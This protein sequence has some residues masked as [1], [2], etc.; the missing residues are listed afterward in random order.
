MERRWCGPDFPEWEADE[1]G[2]VYRNGVEVRQNLVESRREGWYF[3][4]SLGRGRMVFVHRLVAFAFHGDPPEWAPMV[5]H[6]NDVGTDNRPSNLYW[7]NHLTN[8]WDREENAL[9]R[10]G[11]DVELDWAPVS[12]AIIALRELAESSPENL[13]ELELIAAGMRARAAEFRAENDRAERGVGRDTVY[14]VL[15]AA[16]DRVVGGSGDDG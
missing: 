12:A 7:G 13:R 4:V 16:E 10:L 8:A 2:R 6:R 5:C 3:Q 15:R 11:V 14:R 1:Q 9:S